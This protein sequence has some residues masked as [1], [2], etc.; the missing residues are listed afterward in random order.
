MI[1]LSKRRRRPKRPG[2]VTLSSVA[3]RAGVSPITASRALHHSDLVA[4]ATRDRVLAA[5]TELAYAPNLLARGLVHN[6]T[7]TVGVVVLELA[8]PFFAPMLSA[9]QAIAAKRGFLVVVG[10]SGRDEDEERRYVEHLQQLRIGGIIVSPVTSRLDHLAGARARG[11]PVV[12]MARRWEDG[13]YAAADDVKGGQLVAQHLL[14]RSHRRIGLV[15]LGDPDHTPVQ[16]RVLGFQQVLAAAGVEVREAWDLQVPGALIRHG[17]EAVDQLLA[18]SERPSALFVTSDRKAI[19]VV[20]RLLERGIRV[21]EDIAVVGYDDIPYAACAQVPLTTVAIPT[22]RLGE[23]SAELLFCRLDGTGPSDHR[24]T[25]L[26][27]ELV[28]RASC[29]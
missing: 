24:Q 9:I 25:L 28:V 15:R 7:A 6:R 4:K 17:E 29:P 16:A 2:A 18:L 20:H 5:A 14:E 19:G 1:T 10:E 13:D 26:T 8:N 11:T 3:Q 27:P 22:R 21:P 12:V 23:M